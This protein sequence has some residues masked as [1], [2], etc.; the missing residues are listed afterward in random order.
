MENQ[1]SSSPISP[2]EKSNSSTG[3]RQT[4]L[5]SRF[6]DGSVPV[7]I[8]ADGYKVGGTTYKTQRQ[9]LIALTRHPEARHWTFDRYFRRGRYRIEPDNGES[10]IMSLFGYQEPT[11]PAPIRP[12]F[13][14][15]TRYEFDGR[16]V[17]IDKRYKEIAKL[18]FAGFGRRIYAYGYDPDDVLQ[19]VYKGI[20]VRNK[21]KCP[22]DPAKSTF[23]HYV[24][25]VCRCIVS[26]YHRKQSRIR[27]V[28][29]TGITI[30]TDS[31]SEFKNTDVATAC[32][33][34]SSVASSIDLSGLVDAD[35]VKFL[36]KMTKS[37]SESR[38]V[39]DILPLVM[40]GHGKMEIASVVDVP[41]SRVSKAM[42]LIRSAA[43]QW[44]SY[45]T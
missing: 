37:E 29:Q 18:L 12:G 27:S 5:Y 11:A 14:R 43:S 41:P 40:D 16:G 25:M 44:Y 42:K 39:M 31:E 8:S 7:V 15:R 20:V 32:S 17:D 33:S 4:V 28:E 30:G 36:G 45:N 34:I 24:H 6:E 35:F 21:G 9:L 1:M 2:F 13:P 19:E 26:N 10:M 38:M 23:G 22:M 3:E